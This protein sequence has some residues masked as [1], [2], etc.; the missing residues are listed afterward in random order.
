MSEQITTAFKVQFNQNIRLLLQQKQSRL[1]PFVNVERMRGEFEY[2][3]QVGPVEAQPRGPRHS[4]TP[5][6]ETPHFRRRLSTMPYNWADMV[7]RPDK[8]RALIDPTSTYAQNA[9]M[10]FNR[11]IDDI[12]M[13]GVFAPVQVGYMGDGTV[14][15]PGSQ[16]QSFFPGSTAP[17]WTNDDDVL[18]AGMTLEKMLWAK[19]RFWDNDADDSEVA[20]A[21][22]VLPP[23]AFTQMLRATE[24][25]NV[26]YNTVR[27][28]VRG[29]VDTF[30][31]FKFVRSTRVPNYT[32]GTYGNTA[33]PLRRVY[34]CPCWIKDAIYLGVSED[35]TTEI[36]VRPDKN[37]S[38]QVYVEMDMG[39]VRMEEER[40]VAI[41]IVELLPDPNAADPTDPPFVPDLWTGVTMRV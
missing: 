36:D 35:I 7:D 32:T 41:Q 4:D 30:M 26:D 28:L 21:V 18:A 12:I 19:Q 27:T 6:Y 8:I 22:M 29:D 33:D 20:S 5:L 15:F 39:A 3:D 14:N 40:V 2:F 34:T 11:K 16:F 24:I 1:R 13:R 38:T 17:V 25:T 10:A 23:V 37:Y 9:V 31:G